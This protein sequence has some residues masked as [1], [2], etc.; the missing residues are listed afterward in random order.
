MTEA[1]GTTEGAA[2][3]RVLAGQKPMRIAWRRT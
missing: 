3:R 1:M 2:A